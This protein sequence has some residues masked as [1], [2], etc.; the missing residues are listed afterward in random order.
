[1]KHTISLIIALAL[2]FCQTLTAC[3]ASPQGAVTGAVPSSA[4]DG[5]SADLESFSDVPQDAWYADAVSFVREK[6]LMIG[7]TG[8]K[9]SPESTFRREQ[10]ALVLYR[11]AGEPAVSGEDS[12]SDTASGL[13]YSDAILWAEQNAV[14]EGIGRG[15]YGINRPV[16]QEQMAAMLWR[17]EGKPEAAEAADASAYAAR[18]VG[19]VRENGMA[20]ESK[21]NRFEPHSAASRAQ[22]AVLLQ[23]YL[24]YKEAAMPASEPEIRLTVNGTVLDVDWAENSSVEALKEL[25]K[26]GDISLDMSDYGGFEKGAPL[27]ENLPQNNEQMSTDAGDI[28][29]YQGKQFVIYYDQNSWSLTPLGKVKGMTKAGLKE[30]LGTGNAMAVL[31]LSGASESAS[32]SAKGK[33]LVACFSA[34]G[35]TWP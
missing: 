11:I 28:I 3:A 23:G 17:M 35:N 16:T 34:T 4:P 12:F 26:K 2:V 9:F 8:T 25:L 21:D 30:L 1:M 19:W 27:P 14:V 22:I 7:T 31:S 10:L 24:R 13:W 18:A 5:S 29:L 15:L 20:Q 32:E 6:G 33:T